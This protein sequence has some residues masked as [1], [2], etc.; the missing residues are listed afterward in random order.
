MTTSVGY[1]YLY[2]LGYI[3]KCLTQWYEVCWKKIE[4]ENNNYNNN[5]DNLNTY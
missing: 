1:N 3:E 4:H 2:E 5:K